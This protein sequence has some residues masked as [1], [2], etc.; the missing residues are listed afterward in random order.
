MQRYT[1]LR[2]V[3]TQH[4]TGLYE[5]IG[6]ETLRETAGETRRRIEDSPFTKGV[7]TAM[8]DFSAPIRDNIEQSAHKTGEIHDMMEAMYT[9]F[10]K[11]HSLEPFTPPPFSMLKY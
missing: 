4:T 5:T 8:S 9:R 2:N 7:R 3:F 11:E 10:A 6:L 1:A